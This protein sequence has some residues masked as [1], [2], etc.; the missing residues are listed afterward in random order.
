MLLGA[1]TR[2]VDDSAPYLGEFRVTRP[3]GG[4]RWIQSSGDVLHDASG[5]PVRIVG[6]HADITERKLAEAELREEVETRV[7]VERALRASEERCAKAF[8]TSPDALSIVR[9]SDGRFIEVNDHWLALFGF[10]PDE[11]VGRTRDDLGIYL[12]GAERAEF[13]AL[14]SLQGYVRD[15]E[16]DVRNKAGELL[17][18]VVASET[19]DVGG[20]PCVITLMRDITESRRAERELEIQRREITHL[21]RVSLLGEL[22]GAV[23]HEINQPLAAILANTRAAQRMLAQGGELDREEMRAILE[24]IAA[25]DCRAGEVIR[26]LRRMLSKGDNAPQQVVMNEVVDEILSLA[27]S[28]VLQRGT[29]VVTS[30]TPSLPPIAA[31]RVQLQQVVLNLLVNACDAMAEL[32]PA[33]RR[34]VISTAEIGPAVRV[35]VSDRGPGITT[36]PI[37][38]IFEQFVTSKPHGLGLGL[39]ICRSIVNAHGGRLW[40]ENNLDRG[41]TFYLLLP[42][43]QFALDVTPAAR[44]PHRMAAAAGSAV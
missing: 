30:L 6:V 42:R 7:R 9:L 17:R 2:T 5:R 29:T 28:E 12:P 16:L 36:Q 40:A 41:A 35:S 32:P 21:S 15:F 31:D 33:E 11:A 8:R 3:D 4:S 24:D 1:A 37:E 23:A 44:S 20:D 38:T 25:D 34:V 14:L 27:R 10:S 39:S 18:V 22:S 43:T 26:R 13:D 19:V